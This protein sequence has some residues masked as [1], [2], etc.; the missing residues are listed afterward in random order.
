MIDTLSLIFITTKLLMAVAA[1]AVGI[2]GL[3]KRE[4]LHPEALTKKGAIEGKTG[5]VLSI[6]YILIGL[7]LA[8]SGIQDLLNY[9]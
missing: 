8:V 5:T 2:S 3:T 7:L 4:V 1:L 6:F 9:L